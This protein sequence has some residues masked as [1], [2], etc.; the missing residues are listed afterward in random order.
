M[1]D[2]RRKLFSQNFL[3]NQELVDRLID[4]SSIGKGDLVLEIGPGR[5]VITRSLLARAGHVVA[6]EIDTQWYQRLHQEFTA[7]PKLTLY[8]DDILHHALPRLP[9][10]VFANIPFAIEGKIVRYLLDADNPPQD[11]YV[12]VMSQLAHRLAAPEKNTLFAALHTPWFQFS[13]VH[14][15]KPTDFTPVPQV[16]AS[17]F[18][19]TRLTSPLLNMKKRK[20]Y[21]QFVQRGFGNGQSVHSNLKRF[22]PEPVVDKVLQKFSIR[23]KSKPSQVSVRRWI[24]LFETMHQAMNIY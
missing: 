2:I 14:E 13:V 10:K 20:A 21:Q 16:S 15:F 1:K 7:Q 19:F 22:Y 17:L 6:V 3:R 24:V 5:G 9:Y 18:R 4:T 12:V 23:K 8:H 11:T